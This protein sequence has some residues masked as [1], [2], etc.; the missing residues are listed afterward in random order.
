METYAIEMTVK[1]LSLVLWTSLPV[2]LIATVVGVG[3]SLI[4]ALTQIQDQTLP[5]GIKLVAVF[6][7]LFFTVRWM[8]SE[9]FNFTVIIFE[10]FGTYSR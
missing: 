3:V 1:S 4:Q 10:N 2:I 8:G 9:I 7:G 6:V 5:F